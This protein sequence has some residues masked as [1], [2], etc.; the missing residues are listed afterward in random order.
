MRG[1]KRE[2]KISCQNRMTDLRAVFLFIPAIKAIPV[3][4]VSKTN[5]LLREG[6]EFSVTCTIKDVSTSVGSMW[7]KDNSLVSELF[8]SFISTCCSA[9]ESLSIFLFVCFFKSVLGGTPLACLAGWNCR[10]VCSDAY[11]PFMYFCIY[12]Y[13]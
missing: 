5:Y 2:V 3:V 1:K 9:W 13:Y 6:E 7:L 4:S 8:H 11:L 10:G 12:I